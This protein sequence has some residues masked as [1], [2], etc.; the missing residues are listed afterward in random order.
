MSKTNMMNNRLK[1]KNQQVLNLNHSNG[2]STVLVKY[3]GWDYKNHNLFC[4]FKLALQ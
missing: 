3:K 2:R 4:Y 1:K